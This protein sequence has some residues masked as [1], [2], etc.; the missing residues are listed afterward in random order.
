MLACSLP[1]FVLSYSGVPCSGR[2]GYALLLFNASVYA[3]PLDPLHQD[4]LDVQKMRGCQLIQAVCICWEN[5]SQHTPRA[6]LRTIIW[7][8]I[9]HHS[10][11][12]CVRNVE[13]IV[14]TNT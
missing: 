2:A 9:G 6:N 5:F 14:M 7:T 12:D 11:M 1:R 10:C 13:D 4:T 3:S 8:S